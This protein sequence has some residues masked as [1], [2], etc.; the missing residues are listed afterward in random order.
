[1]ESSESQMKLL[2]A[3]GKTQMEEELYADSLSSIVKVSFDKKSDCWYLY[4]KYR[5]TS[6]QAINMCPCSPASH[7]KDKSCNIS[8]CIAAVRGSDSDPDSLYRVAIGPCSC[9]FKWPSCTRPLHLEAVDTLAAC[10]EK[11]K[12]YTAAFSTALGLIRLDPASAIGY[13]RVAKII[14]YLVRDDKAPDKDV[15]RSLA[16]LLRDAKL[17]DIKRLH[18]CLT[19]LVKCGLHNTE[20]YRHSPDDK[21]H[22][23]LRQMAHNLKLPQ[24]RRDPF[25]KLPR[26]LIGII[27]SHLDTTALIRCCRVNKTWRRIIETDTLLWSSISLKKPTSS[28]YFGKFLQR[29]RTMRSLLIDDFS[30]LK[31][32]PEK[33][34]LILRLPHLKRLRIA[35][36]GEL[37]TANGGRLSNIKAN[38]IAPLVRL[39]LLRVLDSRRQVDP[40]W[41]QIVSRTASSLEVLELGHVIVNNL[42]PNSP[43]F[44]N[45][46]KLYLCSRGHVSIVSL[47]PSSCGDEEAVDSNVGTTS[48]PLL[49]L[50]RT[51]N[52]SSRIVAGSTTMAACP[53]SNLFDRCRLGNVV[54]WSLSLR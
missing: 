33:L 11:A 8:Q 16:A 43:V 25:T 26:E 27:F 9:G 29:H 49:T 41:M 46:K 23:I 12:R 36:A 35:G 42:G 3:K 2:L 51:W 1:M 40:V 7:G 28:R 44:P 38:E 30:R 15:T 47:P 4:L 53:C 48:L 50:P 6:L 10:L 52:I 24:S 39:S 19:L 45:L 14:R 32:S 54:I 21:Y 22:A 37:V 31:L 20:E 13:C 18:Q 5:L 17:S 34:A